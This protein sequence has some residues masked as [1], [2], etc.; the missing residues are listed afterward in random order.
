MVQSYKTGDLVQLKS[1][2]PAMTVKEAIGDGL[3]G[4]DYLCQ[5]FGGSTLKEGVFPANSL[6]PADLAEPGIRTV[7]VRPDE[8]GPVQR[9]P[10]KP[11]FED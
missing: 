3:D 11:E 9:P 5:W 4:G 10:L 7:L 6:R 8:K 2:G 1:G